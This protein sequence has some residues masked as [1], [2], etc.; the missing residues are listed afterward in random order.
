M[1]KVAVF[2]WKVRDKPPYFGYNK[3]WVY[4]GKKN[5]KKITHDKLMMLLENIHL[6]NLASDYKVVIYPKDSRPVQKHFKS[7]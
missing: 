6:N 4:A 7:Q 2:A 3:T 5:L 1:T